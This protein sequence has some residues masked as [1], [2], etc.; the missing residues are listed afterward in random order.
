MSILGYILFGYLD[1]AVLIIGIFFL[2]LSIDEFV[3]R[4]FKR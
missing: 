1:N 4:F 3:N 2:L